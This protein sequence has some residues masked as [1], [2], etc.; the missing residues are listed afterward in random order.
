MSKKSVSKSKKEEQ[1]QKSDYLGKSKFN[2][3]KNLD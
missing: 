2:P 1:K 3:L